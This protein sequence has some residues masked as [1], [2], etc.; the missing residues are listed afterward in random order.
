MKKIKSR[1]VYLVLIAILGVASIIGCSAT[2]SGS[3]GVPGAG[4]VNLGSAG[5]SV[6]TPTGFVILAKTGISTVS[7]SVI[8]GDIGLSP[9]AETYI[10]G[11][12][13]IR[14]VSNQWSHSSQLTGKSYAANLTPPTPT[15][16]TTAIADMQTAYVDAAGRTKPDHTELGAGNI[17]GLTL[18]PGLYKWGTTVNIT[19][20][21]TISGSATDSWVFQIAG[22]LIEASAMHVILSGG[23]LPQNIVWQVAGQVT[24]HPSAVFNGIVLCKTAIVMETSAVFNGRAFAQS[25]VTLN[26]NAVTIK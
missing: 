23:A 13:L 17:G 12:A 1:H 7:P 5:N 6:G 24:L 26:Q 21:V 4:P 2:G 22:N 19:T 10:T 8:I 11:F 25:A 15:K 18:A 3:T 20:D 16:M 9:A 14:D